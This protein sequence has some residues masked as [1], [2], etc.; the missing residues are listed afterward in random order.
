MTNCQYFQNDKET[1]D[2]AVDSSLFADYYVI[3]IYNDLNFGIFLNFL[4][5][6]SPT[7]MSWR[8]MTVTASLQSVSRY[9]A[10]P[11]KGHCPMHYPARSTYY[12][13]NLPLSQRSY[14]AQSMIMSPS[15]H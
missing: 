10:R 11:C 6:I 4:V 12:I 1:N 13:A 9:T 5:L 15:V 2:D 3:D 8:E 7:S 14:V